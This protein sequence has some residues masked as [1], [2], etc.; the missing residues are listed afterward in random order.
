MIIPLSRH[1]S[2]GEYDPESAVTPVAAICVRSSVYWTE[3]ASV[4]HV[5]ALAFSLAGDGS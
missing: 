1:Y 3:L 4:L 5:L 2:C